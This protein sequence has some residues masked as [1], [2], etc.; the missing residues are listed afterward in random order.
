MTDTTKHNTSELVKQ[1]VQKIAEVT[2]KRE[3]VYVVSNRGDSV[4]E[5]IVADAL[6][7]QKLELVSEIEKLKIDTKC[8]QSIYKL[9]DEYIQQ[10]WYDKGQNDVLDRVVALL[11]KKS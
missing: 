10:E 11:T 1:A 9:G 6:A 5:K 8:R 3:G 2:L 7:S 4:V